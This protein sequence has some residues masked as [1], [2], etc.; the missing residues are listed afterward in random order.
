MAVGDPAFFPALLT[1]LSSSNLPIEP[2]IL[3]SVLLCFIARDKHLIL[4]TYEED[5]ALVVKLAAL[6]SLCRYL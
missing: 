1:Q 4:R 5:V 6:V 3:Q 2:V